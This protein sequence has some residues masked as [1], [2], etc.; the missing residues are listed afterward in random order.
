MLAR[1]AGVLRAVSEEGISKKLVPEMR[2]DEERRENPANGSKFG[3]LSK[4]KWLLGGPFESL[5][6]SI[7]ISFSSTEFQKYCSM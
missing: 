1:R 6:F 3:V 7:T 4:S 5:R 2:G